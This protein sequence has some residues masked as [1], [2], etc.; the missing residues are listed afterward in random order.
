MEQVSNNIMETMMSDLLNDPQLE[1]L[2]SQMRKL[3][4]NYSQNQTTKFQE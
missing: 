1:E 4:V 3:N 2:L